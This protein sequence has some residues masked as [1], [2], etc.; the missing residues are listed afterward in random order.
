MGLL[1]DN[2]IDVHIIQCDAIALHNLLHFDCLTDAPNESTEGAPSHRSGIAALDVGSDATGVVFSF[3]DFVWF[4]AFRPA[5]DDLVTATARRF[6]TTHEVAEQVKRD[7]T[8]AKRMGDLHAESCV[9]FRKMVSQLESATAE[10]NKLAPQRPVG[11]C[12]VTGGGGQTHGLLRFL[13]VG[14]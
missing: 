3:P 7:P 1:R 2:G 10:L 8:K 13:R 4:R 11:Q 14:Q 5:V 6:K 9:I 12:L